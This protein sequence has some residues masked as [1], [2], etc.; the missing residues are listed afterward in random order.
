[1]NTADSYRKM[2]DQAL[3]S[4]A[5]PAQPEGLYTPI[6]YLLSTGGKRMRPVLLMLVSDIYGGRTAT[7]I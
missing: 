7:A 1:M 3:A 6:S 5:Y 2:I 4:I